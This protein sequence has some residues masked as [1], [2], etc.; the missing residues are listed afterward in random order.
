MTYLEA[1][2]AVLEA[3]KRPMTVD[4]IIKAAITEGLLNPKGKTPQATLSAT[5]YCYIRDS[6]NPVIERHAK[7]ALRY[8]AWGAVSQACGPVSLPPDSAVQ[9]QQPVGG[10]VPHEHEPPDGPGSSLRVAALRPSV[11]AAEGPVEVGPNGP[12]RRRPNLAAS[13]RRPAD[14]R[15]A[16]PNWERDRGLARTVGATGRRRCGSRPHPG[17]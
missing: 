17:L 3:H 9:Q 7:P 14:T 10:Q 6:P 16:R 1:T 12:W 15:R 8:Q 2:L 11:A 13:A 4:E 5:L